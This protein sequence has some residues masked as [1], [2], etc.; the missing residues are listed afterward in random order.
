VLVHKKD[1][2]WRLCI[3]YWALNKI[4][5]RNQYPIPLIDDLLDQF[6]GTKYFSKIDLKSSYHQVP[7]EL[8]DVWKVSFKSKEGLF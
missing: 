3:D 7:I 4:T 2:T 5:V 8:T 1:R 6:K